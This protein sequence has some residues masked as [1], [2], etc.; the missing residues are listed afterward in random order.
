MLNWERSILRVDD[1]EYTYFD[2]Y[3]LTIR[4][5]YPGFKLKITQ[6]GFF[7]KTIAHFQ[8][9]ESIALA[10]EIAVNLIFEMYRNQYLELQKMDE[11]IQEKRKN[12]AFSK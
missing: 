4:N 10:K 5:D 1:H 12:Q 7:T 6:P 9:L 11:Y 3:Y 2:K 8:H